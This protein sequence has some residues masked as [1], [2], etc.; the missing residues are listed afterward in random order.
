[1]PRNVEI[2]ARISDWEAIKLAAVRL[3]DGPPQFLRQEDLFYASPRGR[4]KLRTVNEKTELIYYERPDQ[5]GPKCCEYHL[6]PITQPD[7]ARRLLERLHGLRG[8]IRK[9]RC[10]YMSGQ[11]RIHLDRV[12]NLGDFVELEV[13]LS[14][15]QTAQ[16]GER[17][18][19]L[20]MLELG[21]AQNQLLDCAYIDLLAKRIPS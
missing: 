12:E 16:E 10:L 17:I 8:T 15:N 4:L 18:A 21:I 1:M 19:H 3:A 9:N 5:S 14:D 11:T 6:L 13:M 2:K 7:I 20:L